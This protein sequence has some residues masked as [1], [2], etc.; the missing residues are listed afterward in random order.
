MI[1]HKTFVPFYA[2]TLGV[3]AFSMTAGGEPGDGPDAGGDD[4]DGSDD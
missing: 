1:K 4:G 3:A 2:S